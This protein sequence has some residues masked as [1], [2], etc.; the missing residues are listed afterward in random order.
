VIA[1]QPNNALALNNMAWVA[2][3]LGRADAVA[4]AEKA[5]EVAPNQP[6]FMDT[7][8]LLLSEKKE[9]AR[10]LTLQKKVVELQPSTPL[11]KLNLAKIHINAGDKAA[12]KPLL[13]ELTALG[14]KFPGQAEVTQLK[15]AL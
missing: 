1:L 6:A 9:H 10:A 3:K 12:A 5:N 2:G 11:F 4:L 13:D 14:D 15:G 7:L 8:A